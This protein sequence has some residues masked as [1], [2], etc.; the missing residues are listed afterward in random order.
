VW[1]PVRKSL[2]FPQN[3]PSYIAQSDKDRK[4]FL[5]SF[6]HDASTVLDDHPDPC[7]VGGAQA[8]EPGCSPWSLSST[9]SLD[10]NVEMLEVRSPTVRL[11]TKN[12]VCRREAPTAG[13]VEP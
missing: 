3:C 13:K 7:S 12:K 9:G 1:T 2:C 6:L 5:H 10:E 4:G 11:K 8:G